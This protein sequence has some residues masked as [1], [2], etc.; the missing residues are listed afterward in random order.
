MPDKEIIPTSPLT[1]GDA[2]GMAE[3]A[4]GTIWVCPQ[5][6]ANAGNRI[7]HQIQRREQNNCLFRRKQ[8][9]PCYWS[10]T[11]EVLER[12]ESSKQALRKEGAK[13]ANK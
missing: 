4:A 3:P 11:P 12:H 1:Q 9:S 6:T 10:Q 8:L 5:P 2:R 13:R 7:F